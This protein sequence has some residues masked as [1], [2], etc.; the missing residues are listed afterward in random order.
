MCL[1]PVYF[2]H[3]A[4]VQIVYGVIK[5][6]KLP[7]WLRHVILGFTALNP[8][9]LAG[10]AI[11]GQVDLVPLIFVICSILLITNP[12]YILWASLFYV[13]SLLAKFQ[14]IMF[15]PV[16]GGLFLRHYRISWKGLPSALAGVILV[17]FP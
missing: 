10:G 13:L 16:F 14:M 17:L 5:N 12:K 2:A 8:A 7:D 4:L 3:L 11:W 9:L 1:W 6:R 15:L